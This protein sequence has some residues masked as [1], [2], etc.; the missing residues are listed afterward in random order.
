M[1][2]ML[3]TE[4]AFGAVGA[5]DDLAG[6]SGFV[7]SPVRADGERLDVEGDLEAQPH[8]GRDHETALDGCILGGVLLRIDRRFVC[9]R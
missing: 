1:I 3:P 4:D 9:A 8:G 6:V 5:G 2:V 7:G